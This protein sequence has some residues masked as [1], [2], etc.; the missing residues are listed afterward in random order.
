MARHSALSNADDAGEAVELIRNGAPDAAVAERFG[1]AESTAATWRRDGLPDHAM[2]LIQVHGDYRESSRHSASPEA[3]E[4]LA[5]I[6]SEQMAM[7]YELLGAARAAGKGKG[8]EADAAHRAAQLALSYRVQARLAFAD[9][10]RTLSSAQR[11]CG[12]SM[13]TG[14]AVAELGKAISAR[15]RS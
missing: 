6:A 13:A 7:G 3:R 5:A 15:R 4:A 2:R 9:A 1:V 10:A 11:A 14:T 12:D 8:V